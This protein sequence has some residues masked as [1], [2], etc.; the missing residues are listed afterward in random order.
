[1]RNL[2]AAALATALLTP[3]LGCEGGITQADMRRHAIRRSSPEEDEEQPAT[4]RNG[5]RP[6]DQQALK[7][8]SVARQPA[9]PDRA[10]S[11]SAPPAS[12]PDPLAPASPPAAGTS[13]HSGSPGVP[14]VQSTNAGV[15]EGPLSDP[16]ERRRRTLDNLAQ[17]GEALR[18]YLQEKKQVFVAAS[19]DAA[20]RPL[21]SW[22]VELLPYLGHEHLYS[23]FQLDQPWDSPHNRALLAQIPRVYQS[24]E[25]C[26]EKTNYLVFRASY[27]PFGQRPPGMSLSRIEDGLADTVAIVEADEGA[28]VPWTK[29]ADLDGDLDEFR[30]QV[31]NLREDGFFVVWLDG[32]VGRILR[33]YAVADLRAALTCDAGDVFAAHAL[34]A[35]ASATPAVA[36]PPADLEHRPAAATD[37]PSISSE[38]P[39]AAAAAAPA[40]AGA[41]RPARRPV[42][43][44]VSLEQA[45]RLVRDLYEKEHAA[46]QHVYQ[47]RALAQ[48]MIRQC[49]EM[50]DDPAGQYALLEAALKTA[51]RA[52]DSSTAVAAVEQ[53]AAQYAVN[54]LEMMRATL[55]AVARKNRDQATTALVLTKAGGLI[56]QAL[57]EEQYETADSL[58][59]IALAAARQLGNREAAGQLLALSALVKKCQEAFA[60]VQRILRSAQDADDP[61][62]NLR[63]GRYYGLLR[64]EW[65]KGLP[66]LAKGSHARLRELAEAD[67]AAP[68]IVEEQLQLADGWWE[69]G[70][71]DE[72]CQAALYARAAFWYQRALPALPTGLWRAKAEMRLQAYHRLYGHRDDAV[73]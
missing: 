33:Q 32:S 73:Q 6:V 14:A 8:D 29:P 4:S 19:Y 67:L 55:V 1:M 65:D 27:T 28:A 7:E 30:R 5:G 58:C 3:L 54:E 42:P 52:G 20:D 48:K 16:I 17:I 45:R 61:E 31:G 51:I 47:Q 2:I 22:R 72:T 34:R 12:T 53:L 59:Q 50:P 9:K 25:R 56:E 13:A 18:R 49:D 38:T 43:D 40:A 41:E 37:A 24:P 60:D 36:E 57:R 46:Q 64:G 11:N 23:Q 70:A 62:G 66:L 35:A 10:V 68:T 71:A 15:Q 21:L 26:D 44:P 69:Q 39:A 63:V